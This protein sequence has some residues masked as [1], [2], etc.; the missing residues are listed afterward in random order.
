MDGEIRTHDPKKPMV[1]R[2][3]HF[4]LRKSRVF[5]RLT[6]GERLANSLP[7]LSLISIGRVKEPRHSEIV[8]A[9]KR[10]STFYRRS[11]PLLL[12]VRLPPP[13]KPAIFFNERFM[14]ARHEEGCSYM[15]KIPGTFFESYYGS[16]P[17]FSLTKSPV[18]RPAPGH[19]S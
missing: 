15:K 5:V 19:I 13:P 7:K 11:T 14:A 18:L 8:L 9:E 6:T 3:R 4:L 2:R 16:P 12:F 17:N 10:Y 1:C